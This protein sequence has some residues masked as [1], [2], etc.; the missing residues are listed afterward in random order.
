L[1]GHGGSH[2]WE[3]DSCVLHDELLKRMNI[4]PD[5]KDSKNC[6]AAKFERN[7]CEEERERIEMAKNE[8]SLQAVDVVAVDDADTISNSRRIYIIMMN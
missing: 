8:M 1:S 2:G 5:Q 3:E 7:E 4:M 6:T